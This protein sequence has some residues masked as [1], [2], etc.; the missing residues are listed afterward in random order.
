MA[1]LAA[2]I[3]KRRAFGIAVLVVAGAGLFVL[4]DEVIALMASAALGG[5]LT[6]LG[7]RERRGHGGAL[8]GS[9]SS[10]GRVS[11]AELEAVRR[12]GR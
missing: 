1:G 5:A 10:S 2:I 11:C 6:T 3:T 12:T 7:P 9:Q 8:S 4:P